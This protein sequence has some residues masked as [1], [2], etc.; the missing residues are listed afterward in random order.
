MADLVRAS[1]RYQE[2]ERKLLVHLWNEDHMLS[3]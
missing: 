1:T 2:Q 3:K